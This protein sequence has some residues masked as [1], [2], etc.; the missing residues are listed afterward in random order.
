[1]W[2]RQGELQREAGVS[3]RAPA[4]GGTKGIAT[5]CGQ[6]CTVTRF[7]LWTALYPQEAAALTAL[8]GR[9]FERYI[10]ASRAYDGRLDE[11]GLSFASDVSGLMSPDTYRSLCAPQEK[12]LYDRFA[13]TGQRFYHADSNMKAHVSALEEIGVTA[14][15]IG[16]MVSTAEILEQAPRMI[17]NGQIPPTQVLWKGSPDLV[18]DAVRQDIRDIVAA[19]AGP[20]QLVV[21]T[22]GSIN[23][24]TPL[25]N[26]R[27]MFWAAMEYG[28]I[29]NNGR[30]ADPFPDQAL[31][32][33]RKSVVMQIS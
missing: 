27:A 20:G 22:A 21:T 19:G 7:L 30:L 15:N 25:E 23:P 26:I 10:R 31:K 33:D 14:V 11:D 4:S 18:V 24:G 8:V 6:L 32:F 9:T 5:V 16:P 29:D 17:V 3:P 12:M 13:P 2:K 28:R 1:M